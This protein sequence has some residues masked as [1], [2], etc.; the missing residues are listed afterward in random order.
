MFDSIRYTWISAIFDFFHV[1]FEFSYKQIYH[2]YS[3]RLK[4]IQNNFNDNMDMDWISCLKKKNSNKWERERE[5]EMIN[6]NR[7]L[8]I[9][10]GQTFGKKLI[11]IICAMIMIKKNLVFSV[12]YSYIWNAASNHWRKSEEKNDEKEADTFIIHK[13][14]RFLFIQ[15]PEWKRATSNKRSSSSPLH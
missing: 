3:C 1:F 13:N 14:C 6:K 12:L 2:F 7:F 4:P 5:R 11:I 15:Q 8:F 9:V 10:S